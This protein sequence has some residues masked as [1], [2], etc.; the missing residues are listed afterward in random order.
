MGSDSPILDESVIVSGGDGSSGGAG[1]GG[2]KNVLVSIEGIGSARGR[3][4]APLLDQV[5]CQYVPH[6]LGLT[7]GQEIVIRS[8][9]ATFHNVHIAGEKGDLQNIAMI[10]AGAEKRVTLPGPQII[11]VKCDVHPWMTAYIG[12]FDNPFFA[13]TGDDGSFEIK[14]VPAGTYKLAVWHEQFGRLEQ[15]FTCSDDKPADVMVTYRN[16]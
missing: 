12:V 8:S 13:V 4:E 9:D 6:V 1:A 2:L 3:G 14:N 15:A 16:R 7:V 10:N 11:R 5:H